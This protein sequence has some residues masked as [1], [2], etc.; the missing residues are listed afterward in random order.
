M[1]D[2]DETPAI[3]ECFSRSTAANRTRRFAIL[4]R[5]M[6][7]RG[8]SGKRRRTVPCVHKSEDYDDNSPFGLIRPNGTS[9]D[10]RHQSTGTW[11]W[12]PRSKKKAS[13]DFYICLLKTFFHRLRRQHLTIQFSHYATLR[14]RGPQLP[15]FSKEFRSQNSESIDFSWY[16][17]KYVQ[18]MYVTYPTCILPR[19]DR[20]IRIKNDLIPHAIASGCQGFNGLQLSNA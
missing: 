18:S 13:F 1:S 10:R 8:L 9:E 11:W 16:L 7:A 5:V 4:A 2:Y 15:G 19:G 14:C 20:P 6:Y 12:F 17:W 3:T